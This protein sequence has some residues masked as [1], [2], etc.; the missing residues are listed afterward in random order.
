LRLEIDWRRA[1]A[2]H[3]A[4]DEEAVK[5]Y[6]ANLAQFLARQQ[7]HDDPVACAGSRKS[8]RTRRRRNCSRRCT[9]KSHNQ[10]VATGEADPGAQ[11]DLAWLCARCGERLD[12]AV[13][14]AKAA[15]GSSPDTAAYLD[16]LAEAQYRAGNR[17]ESDQ[18]RIARR[19][20]H[21]GQ[22]LHEAAG[23][24][25]QG[26]QAVSL[27]R[28]TRWRCASPVNPARGRRSALLR[29]EQ[30]LRWVSVADRLRPVPH[31]GGHARG[32]LDPATGYLRNIKDVDDA[33]RRHVIPAIPGRR[34]RPIRA[35]S[36]H[37]LEQ[38]VVAMG[39]LQSLMGQRASR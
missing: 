17:E 19:R 33:V 27:F 32:E 3:A 22:R 13:K 35:A 14:L 24:A 29:A 38:P 2:A 26:G 36:A 5:R 30:Q 18:A 39:L 8:A 25:V 16:T 1:K 4:G 23:R 20:A 28:L 15:V 12:E 37:A 11:N 31:A 34:T 6:V 9:S 21:A 7:R 10:L